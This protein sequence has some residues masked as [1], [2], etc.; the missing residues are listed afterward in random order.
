MPNPL[1]DAKVYTL[2]DLRSW[3]NLRPGLPPSL[4]VLGHPVAHSV[5]PQMHNA[6]L[7]EL[8]QQHEQ[9]K[10]WRYFKFDI[11]PLDAKPGNLDQALDTMRA[12]KFR[13]I[14]L[15]IPYKEK[16][17]GIEAQERYSEAALAMGAVNTLSA[18]YQAGWQ[19]YNTDG[20]GL[21][22]ALQ[23]DLDVNLENKF[24]VILGSG[25]AARGAAHQCLEGKCSALRIGSR[26]KKK[27][28]AVLDY[29]DP[30]DVLPKGK[31]DGFDIDQ[32]PVNEWPEDMVLINATSLGLKSDDPIPF[33]VSF[34]GK[35]CRVFDMV[36][37]REGVTKFVSL[38]RAHGLRASDGLGML[39]WQGA[40]SLT[41]WI[42][43]Q[44]KIKIEPEKIAPTMMTAACNA[45]GLPPRHV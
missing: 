6:A 12:K 37:N 26:D 20:Y 42:E 32:A 40:K 38:A 45:L 11:E 16:V 9:L 5:S 23:R 7:A 41:I 30:L 33:D 44:E 28:Q 24:V 1:D 27:R 19:Y 10:D 21:A 14:N 3:E 4:A 17:M 39:V 43:V 35:S 31:I 15:T 8:A 25:G 2:A 13:G 36:Y 29:I 34:L 18:G 22:Q